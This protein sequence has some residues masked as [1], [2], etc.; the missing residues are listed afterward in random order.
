MKKISLFIAA[1]FLFFSC[2]SKKSA[3]V[4]QEQKEEVRTVNGVVLRET[5]SLCVEK[6]ENEMVWADDIFKGDAVLVYL[7]KENSPETKKA[8]AYG[9]EYDFIHCNVKGRGDYWMYS[10]QVA[11][12]AVP[13]VVIAESYVYDS[14]DVSS[15]SS[16]KIDAAEICAV[17]SDSGEFSKITIRYGDKDSVTLKDVYIKKSNIDKVDA[18]VEVFKAIKR[19]SAK[20]P[21]VVV[22]EVVDYIF[23]KKEFTSEVED[24]FYAFVAKK[25]EEEFAVDEKNDWTF[26]L[27]AA[28]LYYD[29]DYDYE[30]DDYS[31]YDYDDYDDY[32]DSSDD[33]Y[34]D[35]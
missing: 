9:T 19:L 1:A 4:I 23:T 32:E 5:S 27:D 22:K 13:A 28:D 16:K 31:D 17:H 7:N 12:D 26:I 3:D 25:Y 10:S 29:Y 35:N 21:S 8:V 14:P 2:G 18:N 20:T 34:D 30:D 6:S 11:V 15:L 24:A 33:Y